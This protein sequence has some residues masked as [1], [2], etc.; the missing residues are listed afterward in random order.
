MGVRAWALG[1]VEGWER[2]KMSRY[3]EDA[4][5]CALLFWRVRLTV[6]RVH[7][8]AWEGAAV[9]GWGRGAVERVR[10]GLGKCLAREGRVVA[11]FR[12]VMARFE[13]MHVSFQ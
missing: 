13:Y 3:R 12:Q 4:K 6:H 10:E 2:S 7:F 11:G 9:T 1:G 5:G 8:L